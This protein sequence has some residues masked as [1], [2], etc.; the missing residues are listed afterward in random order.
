M[1]LRGYRDQPNL[2]PTVLG[3]VGL[4]LVAVAVTTAWGWTLLV[5]GF[6]ALGAVSLRVWVIQQSRDKTLR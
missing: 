2:R 5:P 3:G 4:G 6:I 1:S